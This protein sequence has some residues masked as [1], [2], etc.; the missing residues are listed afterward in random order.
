METMADI[1]EHQVLA[2]EQNDQWT[3]FSIMFIQVSM[4]EKQ[5]FSLKLKK[6]DGKLSS[7]I[8]LLICQNLIF[9]NICHGFHTGRL[10]QSP[11]LT[12][13][14]IKARSLMVIYTSGIKNYYRWYVRCGTKYKWDCV[15]TFYLEW[16]HKNMTSYENMKKRY[17]NKLNKRLTM[18]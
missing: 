4:G 14:G 5:L 3:Q 15:F 1:S 7:L 10:T 12:L 13:T 2:N 9:R 17:F 16:R 18:M 11:Y 6:T 8:V